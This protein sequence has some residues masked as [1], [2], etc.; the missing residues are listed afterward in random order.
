MTHAKS[1]GKLVFKLSETE[2]IV[3]KVNTAPVIF[4]GF[5]SDRSI[6]ICR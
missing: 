3:H 6:L 5:L 4:L 2:K 1:V